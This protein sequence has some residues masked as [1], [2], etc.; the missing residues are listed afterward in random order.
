MKKFFS[1]LLAALM[2][3]AL[4]SGCGKKE[5]PAVS[6][7][8]APAQEQPAAQEASA[9]D[10]N[11]LVGL[12]ANST[13]FMEKGISYDNEVHVGDQVY[14]TSIAFKGKMSRIQGGD[15]ENPTVTITKE[16][17]I[18]ILNLGE[19]TGFKMPN[20]P[21]AN[22]SE[23][24]T[25]DLK[26]EEQMDKD[27]IQIIGSEDVN[28]EPCYLIV[29]KDSVQG[30]EMKM[31]IHKKYG[32][33]MKMEADSPD[34]KM[35]LVVRNLKVGDVPDSLFDIPNDIVMMEMPVLPQ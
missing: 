26:P 14:A 6:P 2:L 13:N 1:V 34:G 27:A 29:T 10:A 22:F 28:G 9:I 11:A 15:A 17:G 18:Y 8:A 21:E 35:N 20:D 3:A 7:E 32:I 24:P 25:G 19:K 4:V 31:W 30:Y 33:V 16:D 23:D 12:M 5:E